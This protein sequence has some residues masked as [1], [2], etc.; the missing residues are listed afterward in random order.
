MRRRTT[1]CSYDRWTSGNHTVTDKEYRRADL[2]GQ[3]VMRTS[4]DDDTHRRPLFALRALLSIGPSTMAAHACPGSICTCARLMGGRKGDDAVATRIGEQQ[5]VEG[6]AGASKTETCWSMRKM[7]IHLRDVFMGKAC[8]GSVPRFIM[9]DTTD[10]P[11]PS[12]YRIST[13]V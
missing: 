3:R 6:P 4:A 9:K 13:C 7:V 2:A 8:F 1:Y 12:E 11:I 5:R 10:E